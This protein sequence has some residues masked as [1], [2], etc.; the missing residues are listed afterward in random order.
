MPTNMILQ[1][2]VRYNV[3]KAGLPS[4][5]LTRASG[6]SSVPAT[7]YLRKNG[8]TVAVADGVLYCDQPIDVSVDLGTVA[9]TNGATSVVSG[10]TAAL[11]RLINTIGTTAAPTLATDG[12]VV[13]GFAAVTFTIKTAGNVKFHLYSYDTTSGE[14]AKVLGA[15]GFGDAAGDVDV[16]TT[17]RRVTFALSGKSYDRLFLQVFAN[18]GASQVDVWANLLLPSTTY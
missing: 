8:D 11:R 15:D 12:F 18:A 13:D 16:N 17:T 6:V 2:G 5:V 9:P 4:T 14:W 3:V 7:G 1:P 10:A